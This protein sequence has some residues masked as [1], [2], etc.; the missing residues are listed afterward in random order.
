[1]LQTKI[2]SKRRVIT[3][4]PAKGRASNTDL[5]DFRRELTKII[6]SL[7]SDNIYLLTTSIS[8]EVELRYRESG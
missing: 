8:K 1:M 2:L 6:K 3:H 4:G 5:A 7:I